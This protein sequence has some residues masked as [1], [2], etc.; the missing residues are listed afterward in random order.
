MQEFLAAYYISTLSSEEQLSL[1]E[2]TF[3]NQYYEFMWMMYV[4]IVG[5]N[6]DV[7]LRFINSENLSDIQKDKATTCIQNQKLL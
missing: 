3:W 5:I 4:G 6:S 2:K 7:F 1:I